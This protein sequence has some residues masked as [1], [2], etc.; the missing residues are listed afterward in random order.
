MFKV[1]EIDE[2]IN[3]LKKGG[4][5]T[6]NEVKL[7]CDQVRVKVQQGPEKGIA[8][9]TVTNCAAAKIVCSEYCWHL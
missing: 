4:T 5:L 2:H 1:F 7:L 3:R 9:L 8:W 6:E